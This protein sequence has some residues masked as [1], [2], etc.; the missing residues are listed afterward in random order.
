[1]NTRSIYNKYTN[2]IIRRN[3]R[4][5]ILRGTVCVKHELQENINDRKKTKYKCLCSLILHPCSN[6][7]HVNYFAFSYFLFNNQKDRNCCLIF[8][9]VM[10]V[11]SNSDLILYKIIKKNFHIFLLHFII[12]KCLYVFYSTNVLSLIKY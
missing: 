4:R 12:V 6:L 2:I 8:S 1:M 10:P 7:S 3:P 5:D 9:L 11:D